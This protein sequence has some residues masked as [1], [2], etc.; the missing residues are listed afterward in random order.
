MASEGVYLAVTLAAQLATGAAVY[1]T[2]TPGNVAGA[3]ATGVASAPSIG[4]MAGAGLTGAT[5]LC[6]VRGL[7]RYDAGFSFGSTGAAVYLADSATGALTQTQPSAT[8]HVIQVIGSAYD[9][10]I[11]YVN[12]SPDYLTHT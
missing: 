12:P 11:L 2:T 1:L 8:D 5:G 7:M 6:L 3:N 4:V 10:H 9:A